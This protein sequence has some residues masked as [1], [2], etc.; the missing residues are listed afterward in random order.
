MLNFWPFKREIKTETRA[1]MSGFTAELISA[2]SPTSA[3][4]VASPR[5]P[6]LRRPPSRSGRAAFASADVSGSDLL[7]PLEHG[8]GRRS[9]ALRGEA[10]FLIR[11]D[12]L[13]PSSDWELRTRDGVPVAYRVSISEAGGGTTQTALAGEVLHFRIGSDPATPWLGSAPLRRAR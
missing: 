6:L 4:A 3:V 11:D 1:V 7:I 9:V 13:V 12:R 10:L 2:R 5:S 8:T